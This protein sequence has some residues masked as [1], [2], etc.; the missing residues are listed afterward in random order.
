MSQPMTRIVGER[1]DDGFSVTIPNSLSLSRAGPIAA[2]HPSVERSAILNQGSTS[3]LTVSFV[4]GRR[5]P[6]RVEAR[7]TNLEILIGR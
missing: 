7:G 6:F 2:R 4:E 1:T 3:V 5:P